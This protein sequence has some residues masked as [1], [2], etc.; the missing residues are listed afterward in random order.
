MS[1]N[2]SQKRLRKLLMQIP[3]HNEVIDLLGQLKSKDDHASD[4]AAAIV[5][6]TLLEHG[7][8]VI[9]LSDFVK[10]NKTG[11]DALFDPERRG[12]LSSF[13]D[14]IKISYAVDL[15]GSKARNDLVRVQKIRN[16]FAHSA[17]KI[18]FGLPEISDL[19]SQFVLIGEA[20]TKD[21]KTA[22]IETIAYISDAFQKTI[23]KTRTLIDPIGGI[24]I[25]EPPRRRFLP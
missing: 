7:L 16:L 1:L 21:A 10:L 3:S 4:R 15:I 25:D 14:R 23:S 19:C 2:P 9:I 8:K 13:S 11:T 22:Y 12:P 20:E 17:A 5:G 6:A 18:H 24:H